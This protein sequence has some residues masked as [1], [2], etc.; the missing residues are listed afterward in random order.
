MSDKELTKMD[1]GWKQDGN[2]LDDIAGGTGDLDD[3]VIPKSWNSNQDLLQ[4]G[5]K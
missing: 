3:K 5:W 2:L 4:Y 1:H